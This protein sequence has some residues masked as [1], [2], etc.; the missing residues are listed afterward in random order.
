[1]PSQPD[2]PRAP[3]KRIAI[4]LLTFTPHPEQVEFFRRLSGG[5]YSVFI[6]V[7]D[8]HYQ[9]PVDDN[10]VSYLNIDDAVCYA[11]GYRHLNPVITLQKATGCSAWEKALYH[12]C[13]LDRSFDHVWF[14]EDDVFIPATDTISTL[15]GKFEDADII[16]S[17]GY[18][19]ET[20]ECEPWPWWQYCPEQILP[21]P[22]GNSMVA[23]V[24]MSRKLLFEIDRR[25][26][27]DDWETGILEI[28]RKYLFIE[29]LFP[30][31]ALHH[32]LAIINCT[33]MQGVVWRKEWDCSE[34]KKGNLYHPV[35]DRSL[36]SHYRNYLDDM[37]RG[38][39]PSLFRT[40][41]E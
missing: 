17:S 11:A 38:T 29:Y 30:T 33:E 9:C 39:D 41:I 40:K 15:D 23:A 36:Q 37:E 7:D 27:P 34:F 12:F 26:N 14:I 3:Q 19:T 28:G 4:V 20:G 24:R 21:L 13:V 2:V 10:N 31:L 16:C 35:K 8:P 5:N 6:C 1:M 22:W 18:K 32:Q 25:I